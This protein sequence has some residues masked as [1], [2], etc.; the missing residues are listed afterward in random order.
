[1]TAEPIRTCVGCSEAKPQS[2]LLRLGLVG[3]GSSQKI[4]VGRNI[5]GRGAWLCAATVG[6]CFQS[7]QDKK[8]LNRA[9]KTKLSISA[10][11]DLA[12]MFA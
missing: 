9:F 4:E 7:A 12:E 5:P 8:S 1:M 11:D 3:K 10:S 6:A 2:A